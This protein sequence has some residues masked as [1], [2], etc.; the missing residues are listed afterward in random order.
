MTGRATSDHACRN[1]RATPHVSRREILRVGGLAGFGLSLPRLLHAREVLPPQPV[2]SREGKTF[3]RA[4]QV[5]VLFLHGGHPQQ[6][7]FDPKPD[8]P[9]DLRGEFGAIATSLAGVQVSELLPHTAAIMHKLATIR[10]MSH[11][12]TDHIGASMPA[13]TGHA[14]PPEKDALGDFPPA[15]TDYPPHGAVLSAIRPATGGLPTWMRVGPLMRRMNGTVLHGQSPG[16]LGNRHASFVV[17]QDL[18]PGNVKVDAIAPNS[19]LTELR[20]TARLDLLKQVD[21]QLRLIDQSAEVRTFDEYYQ[22]AF[23]LIGSSATR[24]AFQL[25]EESAEMRARYGKTQFGQRCLLARRLAEAGVPMTYVSYCHTPEGSWDTHSKH[26]PQMKQSLAPTFDQAFA[27]LVNDLGER[28]L[29]DETL[30]IAMAEFGRTPKINT[31]GGRD[32]WPYVYSVALAGAGIHPGTVYGASDKAAAY[33]ISNPRS[34]ADFCATVYHLLGV[35]PETVIH[36]NLGR[37][38]NLI[39]GKPIDPILA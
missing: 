35:P 5:I 21:R 19:D 8:G 39:I 24:H 28:G 9:V 36:D 23:N 4:K 26:F 34:P 14:H 20:L 18:L 12:H 33:P 29:L 25:A 6:E 7:T 30:V 22:R 27:A 38:H 16:M 2:P 31:S 3:G 1:F 10:S 37:P 32:H 11:R 15:P 13:F 17:D